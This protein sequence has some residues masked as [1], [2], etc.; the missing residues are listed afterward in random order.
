M[1]K[2]PSKPLYKSLFVALLAFILFSA[3]NSIEET[4]WKYRDG[5]Y[6][7][8][9]LAFKAS[10]TIKNDTIYSKEIPVAI[11]LK[12]KQRITDRLLMIKA[13]NGDSIGTYVSK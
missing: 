6:I 9:V 11:I 10:F 3:C 2:T 13:I 4:N 1:K 5:F 7:G 12:N 8:D